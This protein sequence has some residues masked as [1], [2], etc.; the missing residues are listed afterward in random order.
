[1]QLTN[2]STTKNAYV[3]NINVSS[4]SDALMLF[5]HDT[6]EDNCVSGLLVR[7]A[8]ERRNLL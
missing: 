1:M 6:N 2:W 4:H 8:K 5:V 3:A 7:G